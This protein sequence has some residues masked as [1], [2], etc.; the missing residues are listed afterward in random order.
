M[1]PVRPH[2][3]NVVYCYVILT[4]FLGSTV[5]SESRVAVSEPVQY[6]EDI[7]YGIVDDV[8]MKLNIAIPSESVDVKNRYPLIL[9]I[10]GGGWKTGG[11]NAYNGRIRKTAERGYVAATISHRLTNEK[12]AQGLPKHPWPAAIY[13]CKAAIRFLKTNAAQFSI[14]AEKIGVTGASSGGHLALMLGLADE[15]AGFEGE[16]AI[17]SGEHS[18]LPIV[19]N[20]TIHAVFNKSGPTE[21]ISCHAAPIV[22]PFLVDLLG[23]LEENREEYRKASPVSHLSEDDPPVMTIH[24]ELDHVVPVEQARIL[25]IRMKKEGLSHEYLE[26][27]GEKHVFTR[28]KGS[29]YWESFYEFFD[30]HLKEP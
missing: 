18:T 20:T 14:D 12:N 25:D 8:E 27:K 10:H 4:C 15:K 28:E 5:W 7:T 17:A 24:G 2:L 19:T 21:L 9:F 11:R 22:T 16:V 26:L 6:I 23:D 1:K 3:Y 13:D 30:R 29:I